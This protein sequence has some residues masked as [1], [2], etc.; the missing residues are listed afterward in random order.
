M[1]AALPGAEL[2]FIAQAPAPESYDALRESID[3]PRVGE[4]AATQALAGSLHC[5]SLYNGA[6]LIGFGRIIGDGAVNFY[7]QDVMI[8]PPYRGRGL[9]DQIMKRLMKW[10]KA[11]LPKSATIGLMSVA[12][13]EPFYERYGFLKRPHATYGAGMSKLAGHKGMDA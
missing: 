12:G 7:I 10:T 5:L 4:S 6:T 1:S 2:R 8:A 9:G 11:T 3:W 13:K